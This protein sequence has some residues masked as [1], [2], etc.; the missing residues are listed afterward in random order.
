MTPSNGNVFCV[1]GPLCGKFTGE[2]PSQKPMTRSFDVS[3][4]MCFSKRLSK[5]SRRRWF[6][7]SSRLLW[8][9]C[10]DTF[11]WTPEWWHTGIYY[12][13]DNSVQSPQRYIFALSDIYDYINLD[14]FFT[15]GVV[16]FQTDCEYPH[17]VWSRVLRRAL[18]DP[19]WER[20]VGSMWPRHWS[21][22]LPPGW[23]RCRNHINIL[24]NTDMGHIIGVLFWFDIEHY[25]PYSSD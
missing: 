23:E 11:D 21:Q 4:N 12:W 16:V 6:Q 15:S 18:W 7:T 5:Q 22:V 19:L 1:T 20:G 2:F 24:N 25:Y 14:S 13:F 9:H 10:N 17:L 3:F 8:R